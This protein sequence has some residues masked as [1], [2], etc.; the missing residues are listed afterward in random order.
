MRIVPVMVKACAWKAVDLLSKFNIF[1]KDGNPLSTF[2]KPEIDNILVLLTEK[3]QELS[4]AAHPEPVIAEPDNEARKSHHPVHTLPIKHHMPYRPLGERFV[5]RVK[6]LWDVDEIL[7]EKG[8][9][10]V[11]GGGLLGLVGMGGIGKSQLA[12]EYA[13]RPHP[14]SGHLPTPG[15]HDGVV[16]PF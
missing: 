5:G 16:R 13:H 6:D 11:E 1:P 2:E 15:S 9:A 10:I 7:R 12:I 8:A 14:Y 4:P 3:L